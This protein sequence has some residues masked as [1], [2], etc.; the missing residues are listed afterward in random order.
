MTISSLLKLYAVALP[1]FLVIDLVW[2]GFIARSFYRTHLGHLMRANVNWVA[3]VVFYLVFVA[4]IVVLVVWPAIEQQSLV[5]ALSLGALFGLVT[6]AAYD[7]TNLAVLE[8]FSLKIALVDLLWGTVLC[9]G[10]SA[11]TYSVWAR[12]LVN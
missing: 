1:T 10:V 7:L 3:A 4:G 8:G 9:A 5:R 6:Y 2:L 11:I 12:L